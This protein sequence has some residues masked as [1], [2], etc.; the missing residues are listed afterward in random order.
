MRHNFLVATV[1]LVAALASQAPLGAQDVELLGERYGTRVPD[2]YLRIRAADP[3]A[4]QFSRGRTLRL[5]QQ[6]QRAEAPSAGPGVMKI[7]G[8]RQGVVEGSYRIPVLTGLFSDSAPDTVPFPRD[9]VQMRYFSDRPGS[10]TAYYT[11]VSGGR[12]ELLG[13][14]HDWI[15][16]SVTQAA[17][18]GGQSG[19]VRGTVGPFIVDLLSRLPSVDWGAFDND[20]PDGVPNSGDDDGYV[21]ALAVIHPTSGAEC[22]GTNK[23]NRIWSHRWSLH[24]AN[25][26]NGAFTTSTPASGGGFIKI[27]DYTIQPVYDCGGGT[28]NE[29]GVFTHELGHA[30]GLPDLYD[31]VAGD[32]KTAGAGNW[33]LMATGSWG[34]NGAAPST[35]CHMSAWSK[36]VLGWVEVERLSG[37]T[38]LGA[39]SLPPVET[40]GRVFRVDAQD[41]SGEYFLLEN[42]RRIGFDDRLVGEGLLVW[43]ISPSI[44]A[45]FWPANQVN[46][47][48]RMGVWLRQADG[49][50]ELGREGCGRGNVGDPFPFV[51]PMKGC[52]SVTVEGENRVFHA[53]SKPSAVSER[54]TPT[55]LTLV[56][57]QLV[58]QDVRFRALTRS[59][60]VTVRAEGAAGQG[61]FTVNGVAVGGSEHTF[62]SYPF[63][64]HEISAAPGESL[65]PGRR[66]PFLA[67]SDDPQA[68]R[69]RSVVVPL[70]DTA[71]VARYGGEQVELA[72]ALTGGVYGV[73]PGRFVTQPQGPDLWFS[74]GSTV[75]VEAVPTRGFSFT[76]WSGALA[77]QP[78]PATLTLQEPASAGAAFALVYAVSSTTVGLVAAEPP[79]TTLAPENGTPPYVWT[80]LQGTLPQGLDLDLLGDLVGSPM[81]VGTFP[82]AVKVR[83]ALGLTAQGTVT[84]DVKEPTLPVARLASRF[85]LTGPTLTSDQV[86]F[87][88]LQGNRDGAYDLGDFRAWVLAHPGLPLTAELRAL[89][90]TPRVIVVPL[91]PTGDG[92]VRR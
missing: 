36:A 91:K 45:A 37:G 53:S 64:K 55:G 73:T 69:A 20:G 82:L 75:T 88:D 18:T 41:G 65:G 92:E 22:G 31:T 9:S 10:I 12:V 32:G 15:R 39:L 72:I 42:R 14:V 43:Q 66:R 68:P 40:S 59:T 35:P 61:L 6:L 56:D 52:G 5:R 85:L 24:E 50:E 48:G 89:V 86:R 76:G 90:D 38:D 21:D 28:L 87:L 83:D 80:V 81:E 57:I 60:R 8:P 51:G 25:Y 1:G 70:E 7:L 58:G 30:F 29:I 63:V 11:E 47:F 2:G 78:N 26:P 44:L 13:E 62:G 33:E 74:Q 71:L 49:L 17:A 79:A 34:C 16:S 23:D 67:W 54:G 27:D 77:G 4:Y 46:A 3:G 19:L 84:L